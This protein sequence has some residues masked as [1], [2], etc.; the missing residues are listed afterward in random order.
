MESSDL[1]VVLC[2][3]GSAGE[4]DLVVETPGRLLKYD[5]PSEQI[6][7]KLLTPWSHGERLVCFT[8]HECFWFTHSF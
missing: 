3:G 7:Q 4:A 5:R 8:I 6:R 1:L 2:W